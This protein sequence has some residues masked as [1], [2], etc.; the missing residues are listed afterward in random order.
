[1]TVSQSAGR[2]STAGGRATVG[3]G[4]RHAGAVVGVATPPLGAGATRRTVLIGQGQAGVAVQLA[5]A[6]LAASLGP[7]TA[8]GALGHAATAVVAT[9]SGGLTRPAVGTAGGL[10]AIPAALTAAGRAYRYPET[11]GVGLGHAATPE[12]GAL[13]RGRAGGSGLALGVRLGCRRSVTMGPHGRMVGPREHGDL[14]LAIGLGHHGRRRGRRGHGRLRGSD[15]WTA[16]REQK[17]RQSVVASPPPHRDE[18]EHREPREPGLLVSIGHRAGGTSPASRRRGL[19][20][21]DA[22]V[23]DLEVGRRGPREDAEPSAHRKGA[24]VHHRARRR[25]GSDQRWVAD[26]RDLAGTPRTANHPLNPDEHS[27]AG[28]VLHHPLEYHGRRCALL[29]VDLGRQGGRRR[30]DQGHDE[31]PHRDRKPPRPSHG[32]S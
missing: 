18:S 20:H 8:L 9:R 26:G 31:Q 23:H 32:P 3:E 24:V 29:L 30:R 19:K 10:A 27:T 22:G 6:L 28:V 12:R 11:V 16:A 21:V 13:A 1:V 25:R 7:A 4:H 14:G 15:A 2:A 17:G 5:A